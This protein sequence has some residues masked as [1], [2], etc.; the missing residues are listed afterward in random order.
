MWVTFFEKGILEMKVFRF[1]F[2][3]K[4]KNKIKN[5]KKF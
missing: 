4:N 2:L 3:K 1:H 5:K